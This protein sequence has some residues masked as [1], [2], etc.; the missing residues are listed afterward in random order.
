MQRYL[1]TMCYEHENYVNDIEGKKQYKKD[2]VSEI[3]KKKLPFFKKRKVL[4]FVQSLC[5]LQFLL[6]ESK[7]TELMLNE[8][9][10][11]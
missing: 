5:D 9:V 3:H 8:E 7:Q 2:I 1:A 10:R 6:D 11:I 4:K